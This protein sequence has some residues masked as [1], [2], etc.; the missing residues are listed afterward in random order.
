MTWGESLCLKWMLALIP[1]FR[2]EFW[3][4]DERQGLLV[5]IP[6][7]HLSEACPK[8]AININ[9]S[10]LFSDSKKKNIDG[11]VSKANIIG[12]PMPFR[13]GMLACSQHQFWSTSPLTNSFQ[14]S[15]LSWFLKEKQQHTHKMYW[16]IICWALRILQ[17]MRQTQSPDKSA[18]RGQQCDGDLVKTFRW[19][20]D[21]MRLCNQRSHIKIREVPT[22]KC[23]LS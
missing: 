23:S 14:G 10:L 15:V 1:F 17:L 11:E 3:N 22:V 13:H 12:H 21:G 2:K 20:E 19:H 16:P 8:F 5:R 7:Q 6:I 9:I 4:Y 18:M